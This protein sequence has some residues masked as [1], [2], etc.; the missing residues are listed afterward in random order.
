[1]KK[2][3]QTSLVSLLV[4]SAILAQATP[5][6]VFKY[7]FENDDA[8]I[9]NEEG[10]IIGTDGPIEP[11]YKNGTNGLIITTNTSGVTRF[12]TARG[13]GQLGHRARLVG[14]I[15]DPANPTVPSNQALALEFDSYNTTAQ[16][17]YNNG[18]IVLQ[19]PRT[20]GIVRK[21]DNFVYDNAGQIVT[22]PNTGENLL[23]LPDT[24][25][26][27]S[28]EN[29]IANPRDYAVKVKI[30]VQGYD[31]PGNFSCPFNVAYDSSGDIGFTTNFSVPPTPAGQP[32]VF[33][34]FTRRLSEFT[35]SR[36]SEVISSQLN[37]KVYNFSP[38]TSWGTTET[39]GL[40][41]RII[42][43]DFEIIYSPLPIYTPTV[44]FGSGGTYSENF[45]GIVD[46]ITGTT[47]YVLPNGW[48]TPNNYWS[49]KPLPLRG[50]E[51]FIGSGNTLNT[52]VLNAATNKVQANLRINN[53]AGVMVPPS[54]T[55][56]LAPLLTPGAY[57][58]FEYVEPDVNDTD[59]DG[60]FNELIPAVD[61]NGNRLKFTGFSGGWLSNNG[62]ANQTYDPALAATIRQ[63][64]LHLTGL[65]THD[66]LD[67][68]MLLATGG[69]YD[70]LTNTAGANTGNQSR[71][72]NFRINVRDGI[73]PNVANTVTQTQPGANNNP[74][75]YTNGPSRLTAA[76]NLTNQYSEQ[77]NDVSGTITRVTLGWTTASAYDLSKLDVLKGIRHSNSD[78]VID[79][80]H[81]LDS[82]VDDEF[83]AIENVKITLKLNGQIVGGTPPAP[84]E[85]TTVSGTLTPAV[86]VTFAFKSVAGKNYELQA[87]DNLA[88]GGWTTIS[89]S[90]I[91]A[92][93]ASTTV[94]IGAGAGA[95]ADPGAAGKTQRFY[96][97]RE[98]AP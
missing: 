11:D 64:T 43:D 39:T 75:E 79:F 73:D 25:P 35:A 17:P 49:V 88:T 26:A 29:L 95:I 55:Y 58:S 20:D 12:S 10:Q 8:Q 36:L 3:L 68:E 5:Q 66:T 38:M 15:F 72:Y 98:I 50:V 54:T 80:F 19:A 67:L 86:A 4:T 69:S 52:G 83:V 13:G 51:E 91:P 62:L 46:P 87:S 40:N 24:G 93:A 30:A 94:N 18:F 84:L 41:N 27:P 63:S 92:T 57:T 82:G 9:T 60:N 32:P 89:T 76:A 34:T 71:E 44:A 21:E 81:G 90:A 14:T 78:L 74:V 7:T 37:I 33:T 45:N 42:V 56:P 23:K 85:I 6:T 77:W 97:V 59:M 28:M 48:T 1:M 22:D 70:G 61:A 65:P 47:S 2:L 96:R 16:Q 31:A 53:G